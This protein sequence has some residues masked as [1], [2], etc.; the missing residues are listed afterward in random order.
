MVDRKLPKSFAMRR[1]PP[2]PPAP[3]SADRG[4]NLGF[5]VH[6]LTPWQKL[7]RRW[8]DVVPRVSDIQSLFIATGR[9]EV[10]LNWRHPFA[11]PLV[12]ILVL[13]SPLLLLAASFG[14]IMDKVVFWMRI[15][16]DKR[17]EG[18]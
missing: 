9:H 2:L 18:R 17:S 3:P 12:V 16:A 4:A 6:A 8:N 11:I 13:L 10:R 15:S 7:R 14:W 5:T 1:L